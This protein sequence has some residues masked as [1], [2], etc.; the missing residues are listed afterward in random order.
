MNEV[1]RKA[2]L[3]VLVFLGAITIAALA[4]VFR[5]G[6]HAIT[7]MA[8]ANAQA[9][10]RRGDLRL[11]VTA[12]GSLVAQRA[13]DISPPVVEDMWDFKIARLVQEGTRVKPG[14]MLVE[15]DG[16]EV[17]RRLL[18]RRAEMDKTQEELNKRKLEY[19]VQLR[20]LHIRAEET[21]VNLEKARHKAEVDPSLISMQDYRQARVELEQAE[22]EAARVSEKLGSLMSMA[23]AEL[24]SLQ[25]TLDKSRLRVSRLEEQQKAL[26]IKAPIEGVVIFKRSWNGEKKA[27]GQSAWQA[28]TIMQIPDLSTLRLE[29]M[30]EEANAGGVSPGQKAIVR[31]DAFPGVELGGVVTSVGTVL[32][33]KRFDIPTKVVD[34]IIEFRTAGEKLLPGMTASA[35]IE[36]QRIPNVIQ[37]PVKAVREISGRTFVRVVTASGGIQERPIRVGRRNAE[38]IEV[39]DGLSEGEKVALS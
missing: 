32:H 8:R 9:T 24:A 17:N 30:V 4:I 36:T 21:K 5:P 27:V 18:E 1:R 20:D 29:A 26:V 37:V 34:A 16:Q 2:R 19:D 11:E 35:A 38:S 6:P 3:T 7:G 23:K 10:V 15:F 13:R 12:N 25:N 31:I 28:E 33:P 39:V 14:D 22:F